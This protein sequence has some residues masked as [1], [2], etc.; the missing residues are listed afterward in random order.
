MAP[1]REL[2]SSGGGRG[3]SGRSSGRSSYSSSFA[4]SGSSSHVYFGY[5]FYGYGNYYSY[6]YYGDDQDITCLPDDDECIS[7]A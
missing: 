7:S 5:G 3:S 4:Y 2:R 1:G 6:H